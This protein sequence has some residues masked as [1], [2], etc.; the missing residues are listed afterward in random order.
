MRLKYTA[1]SGYGKYV[2]LHIEIRLFILLKKAEK[3][4]VRNAPV[5]YDIPVKLQPITF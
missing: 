2:V 1:L 3:H 5:L 4:W